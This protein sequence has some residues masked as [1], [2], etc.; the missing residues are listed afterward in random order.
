VSK[1]VQEEEKMK[2]ILHIG[3]PKTGTTSLQGYLNEPE[4]LKGSGVHYISAGRT[5]GEKFINR[6]VGYLFAAYPADDIPPMMMAHVGLRTT[7]DRRA[8][9][10]QLAGELEAE[11][12]CLGPDATVVISDEELFSFTTDNLADHLKRLLAKHFDSIEILAYVRNPIS[13]VSSA[14]V[15]SVRIGNR[16]CAR[17]FS[18]KLAGNTLYLNAL[19]TWSR[20]FGKENLRVEWYDGTNVVDRMITRLA[21]KAPASNSA[22]FLNTSMSTAGVEVLRTINGLGPHELQ[23]QLMLRN[24]CDK[25]KGQKWTIS[26]DIADFILNV[27]A[28]ELDEI[29][30]QFGV[31]G[32]SV[33]EV[34]ADWT[35]IPTLSGPVE[36]QLKIKALAVALFQRIHAGVRTQLTGYVPATH[37]WIL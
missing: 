23:L 32:A 12:A 2:C 10:R 27:S 18:E 24:V 34:R 36:E 14:Y 11:L 3:A 19:S 17:E 7:E 4:N 28:A 6:H 35:K 16:S 30:D 20:A 26:K 21:L 22:R 33:D 15:Q 9:S 29:I 37:P 8:Y 1:F 5:F 25:I 31:E 13:Y